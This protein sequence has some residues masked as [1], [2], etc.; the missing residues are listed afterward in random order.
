MKY[1]VL[2]P[3][4]NDYRVSIKA[5][6]DVEIIQKAI[7]DVY[8]H[9]GGY[10]DVEPGL[11][12][13]KPIMLKDNVCLN[14]AEGA[15]IVFK[16]VKEWYHN[17]ILTDYE[18]VKR[19]RCIS[20]IMA[21]GATNIGITGKGIIDGDGFNWRPLKKFKVTEKF[22]AKCQQI[23]NTIVP[24]NEGGIWYPTE[25]SFA[26]AMQGDEPTP[27]VEN[28]AKYQD[29]YDYFRPVLVS[30]KNCNLVLLEGVTIRNSPA[31]NVHPLFT[32]NLTIRGCHIMNEAYAQNGDGMDI[33]S[34]EYVL[35][36]D[37]IVSVGDDGICLK[38]GKNREARR[39]VAPTRFV[40]IVGNKVFDAHGGIVIGSEM[41]RGISDIYANNNTFIGT[42]IGLRFKTQIGRGGIVENIVIENTQML[43]IKEEAIILTCGYELYRMANESRD[44]VK[45]I[46]NDDIPEF[47]N[48]YIT[49]L[50]CENA[51]KSIVIQGLEEQPIHDIYFKNVCIKAIK[52]PQETNS[53]NINYEDC[54]IILI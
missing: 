43:N 11:Y 27:T 8:A 9:Q 4:F 47:R 21:D 12:I 40:E 19:I 41:S 32:K 20:P 48:I 3:K 42:D 2:E 18:G 30:I 26:L 15:T 51:N 37:N 28:L 16:K 23:S 17:L 34:C 29:N 38:S 10:V 24:T 39:I 44:V 33:E 54:K 7:D 49:N 13:S 31:W 36:K 46:A 53:Y 35:I 1:K 50:A 22:F 52:A 5:S 6:D 25:S 14:L 45:E